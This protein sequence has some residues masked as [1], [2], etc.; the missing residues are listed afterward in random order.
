MANIEEMTHNVPGA[1]PIPVTIQ[2]EARGR[3]LRKKCSEDPSLIRI[4]SF[5]KYKKIADCF[6]TLKSIFDKWNSEKDASEKKELLDSAVSLFN[7][8]IFPP[9]KQ[10]GAGCL[11]I[12]PV[13]LESINILRDMDADI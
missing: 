3:K 8:K 12:V 7:N 2:Y 13:F 5:S 11:N 6:E 1:K 9:Y 10:E 4:S